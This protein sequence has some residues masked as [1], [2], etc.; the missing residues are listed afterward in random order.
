VGWAYGPRRPANK[1]VTQILSAKAPEA[2]ARAAGI[3]R[4]GGLVA[5]PTDTVYGL[6]A[7]A[8]DS[9]AVTA[10][11]AVKARPDEKSIPIL[12]ATLDQLP[13][14]V[15][16]IGETARRLMAS[17]WPGPL[18]LVLAKSPTLSEAVSRTGTVAVR[19]PNHP[20]ALSLIAAVGSPLAVTSANRSGEPSTSDPAR[21]KQRLWGRIDAVLNGGLAPGGVPSTIVDCVAVPPRIVRHGPI[22]EADILVATRELGRDASTNPSPHDVAPC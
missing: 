13:Q 14:V 19:M 3:L 17:F 12:I 6:G 16:E 18:T 1:M 8:A 4:A 2:L 21:V 20:L 10:L 9:N 15:L 22:S 11:Y 7:L 5:F